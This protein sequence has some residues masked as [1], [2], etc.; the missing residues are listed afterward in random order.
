MFKA[1]P[2]IYQCQ[3]GCSLV[4]SRFVLAPCVRYCYNSLK[5]IL[6]LCY[7]VARD[8]HFSAFIIPSTCYFPEH[9]LTWE[10]YGNWRVC[11]PEH[12]LTWEGYGNRRVCS[13]VCNF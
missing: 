13:C 11:Y 1:R 10:G 4:S 8:T 7:C 6:L 9:V 12:V 5:K 2:S 3:Y